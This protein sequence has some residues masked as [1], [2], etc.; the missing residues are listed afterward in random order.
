MELKDA[1]ELL[2][3]VKVLDD[4]MYQYNPAYLEALD[5]VIEKARSLN[6]YAGQLKWERDVAIGQLNEIGIQF[7]EKMD[8]VKLAQEKRDPEDEDIRGKDEE[9]AEGAGCA[10][11]CPG[12]DRGAEYPHKILSFT[13][14]TVIDTTRI[15]DPDADMFVRLLQKAGACPDFNRMI[16]VSDV[17]AS[18][19]INRMEKDMI[20]DI[21]YRSQ[22]RGKILPGMRSGNLGMH[23]IC[24]DDGNKAE[25]EKD[26]AEEDIH[27]GFW[28][29]SFSISD[30]F[31]SSALDRDEISRVIHFVRKSGVKPSPETQEISQQKLF[32]KISSWRE[33]KFMMKKLSE[34]RKMK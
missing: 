10:A 3:E 24:R 31:V 4:S 5:T 14:P 22:E 25:V 30:L 9:K 26:S 11:S 12:N 15:S 16:K 18:Q 1:I 8:S 13:I 19:E 20:L 23:G 32:V 6:H 17:L 29:D 21:L 2:E 34:I 7:G 28:K 33:K 27:E